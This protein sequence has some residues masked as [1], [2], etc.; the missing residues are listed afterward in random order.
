MNAEDEPKIRRRMFSRLPL[1]LIRECKVV[2]VPN[3]V[4]EDV[5]VTQPDYESVRG[6]PV[7]PP[8]WTE[9]E[10]TDLDML[11]IPVL[12]FTRSQVDRH[13]HRLKSKSIPLTYNL[14]GD[15][16]PPTSTRKRKQ[17]AQA[18]KPQEEEP[19]QP[20]PQRTKEASPTQLLTHSSNV[21]EVSL[22]VS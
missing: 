9:S 13:V 3:Q 14:M 1:K 10:I 21:Q 15:Q 22:F 11:S 2:K 5:N 4:D 18:T 16:R 17:V 19:V 6:T 8:D 7:P 20:E 12:T